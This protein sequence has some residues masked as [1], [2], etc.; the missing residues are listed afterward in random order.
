NVDEKEMMRTF[1]N[2]VGLVAVFPETHTQE[3]LNR[4]A[5]SGEK[6]WPIG[7]VFKTRKNARSRVQL[8]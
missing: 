7:E 5:G 3:V 8:V 1:N 4:L 6:A 2:G